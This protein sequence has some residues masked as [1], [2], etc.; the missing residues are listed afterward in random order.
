MFF[1]RED[2]AQQ[3][4]EILEDYKNSKGSVIVAI[5]RGGVPVGKIISNALN[6]PLEITFIKK[7][8]HPHNKEYAVGAVSLKD[9][10]LEPSLSISD[11]YI[12][13]E[14]KRLR[15]LLEERQNAFYGDKPLPDF[16]GKT[17]IIV[18]DGVATGLTMIASIKLIQ[19]EKPH[20]IIVAIPVGPPDT[21]A[22]LEA[23]VDEVRCI[24][25][26]TPFYAVG[27]FYHSFD[28]VSDLEVQKLL[29][30]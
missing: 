1:D 5:P 30:S 26:H 12:E 10:I 20:K 11:K 18:D 15:K 8:G 4:T 3:L 29:V 28:Q 25:I 27:Q 2:A 19:K 22:R 9:V 14:T 17:V 16:K 13:Q 7:L 21:V 24:E 23:L 6:L